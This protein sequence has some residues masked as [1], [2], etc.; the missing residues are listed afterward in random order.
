MLSLTRISVLLGLLAFNLPATQSN[1][2]TISDDR[3]RSLDITPVLGRGYS[4]MTNSF[5][6]TCLNVD[7]TTVPSYNYHYDFYDFTQTTNFSKEVSSKLTT[8]FSFF[9]IKRKTTTESTKTTKNSSR[10]R[11]IVSNMKLQRYYSSVREEVSPLSDDALTLLDT[12]DYVGFFKACGPNYVRGIRRAQEV[13]A[14][15]TFHTNSDYEAS[16]FFREVRNNGSYSRTSTSSSSYSFQQTIKIDI[17]GWGLGLNHEGSDTLVA[18]TLSEYLQVMR[19]AFRSMTQNKDSHHIGMIYGIEVV[20]WVDNSSFQVA[21]RVLDESIQVP[22]PRSLIKLAYHETTPATA[23]ATGIRTEFKCRDPLTVIDKWGYCCEINSLYDYDTATYSVNGA[24]YEERVCRPLRTLP[25]SVVKN[26][27]ASN[28]EFVARLDRTVRYK[29][30]QM[31][32][33]ERCISYA[34]GLPTRYDYYLLKDQDTVKYDNVQ[35]VDFTLFELKL[36]VDP[37]NDYGMVKH[38]GRE[39][40][41]WMEMY[42]APCLAALF[43]TNIG[44]NPDTDPIYFMAYPWHTHDECTYLSCLANNMRWDRIEGGCTTSLMVGRGAA[45][46]NK[47][48]NGAEPNCAKEVKADGSEE[49]CKIPNSAL[50]DQYSDSTTC[51]TTNI[52]DEYSVT[53]F[54]D[55]FCMP[56]LTGDDEDTTKKSFL[57][58]NYDAADCGAD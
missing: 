44:T 17:L 57:Q 46:Y 9:W 32:T 2:Y 21:S 39:L 29:L 11:M 45:N 1:P 58:A 22:L 27:M 55:H 49:E 15:F 20:P 35:N 47:D 28:G 16:T 24:L 12:Q 25:K 43:G 5:Q 50:V 6:S 42:Y 56:D 8:S 7:Q 14:T 40:D 51:W 19:F 18:S 4:I 31:A 13:T 10:F 38:M 37:R 23:Y 26:N 52:Q 36:A 41:E 54:M 3:I 30:N 53:Y 33:L 48:T 34:R